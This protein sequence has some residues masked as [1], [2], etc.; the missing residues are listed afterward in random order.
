MF[1]IIAAVNNRDVLRNNLFR[2]PD[3]QDWVSQI[4]LK[5]DAASAS[6]AFNEAVEESENDLVLFVHQDVYLPRGWFASL[7]RSV[8]H[9]DE[10]HI[11]WGV[12]GCF[13][14][15]ADIPSGIGRI[16]STGWGRI[17]RAI[18][19]PQPVDTLDEIVLVLRKSSGLLFDADLPHFHLYGTDICLAARKRGKTSYAFPGYCVHNTNQLLTLPPEFF[20]CYRYVKRKWRQYLPIRTPCMT[21]SRFDSQFWGRRLDDARARLMRKPSRA[22]RRFADPT[23]FAE[24]EPC[25]HELPPN[26]GPLVRAGARY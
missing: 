22:V 5:E 3:L 7:D 21:I 8:R 2:S 11:D 1:T 25:A 14:V 26:S 6:K 23:P 13:G 4:V 19:H 18:E 15:T 16:Y 10:A 20:A 9:L 24:N 17:G 12:L